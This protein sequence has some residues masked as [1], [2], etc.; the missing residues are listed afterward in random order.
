VERQPQSDGDQSDR[1]PGQSGPAEQDGREGD[2]GEFLG[3]SGEDCVDQFGERGPPAGRVGVAAG[4]DHPVD[5]V[6]Q[7][8]PDGE[9]RGR[10]ELAQS[11][12][13]MR[14]GTA[15]QRPTLFGRP[16]QAAVDGGYPDGAGREDGQDDDGEAAGSG[17]HRSTYRG[18]Q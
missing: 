14:P 1:G 13:R 5:G 12:R 3:G 8:V 2:E 4:R 17:G 6:E 11:A 16:T 9:D 10:N 7:P 15:T 18:G